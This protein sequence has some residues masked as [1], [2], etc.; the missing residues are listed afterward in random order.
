LKPNKAQSCF[1]YNNVEFSGVS[2]LKG[3]KKLVLQ[4]FCRQKFCP[5]GFG[6]LLT[7]KEK[8]CTFLFGYN[9]QRSLFLFNFVL[10]ISFCSYNCFL[11]FH[12]K[13]FSFI[14]SKFIHTNLL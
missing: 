2:F 8:S 10:T 12:C 9:K 6:R 13:F 4:D 5:F 11:S 3:N 14:Q 1:L 7:T